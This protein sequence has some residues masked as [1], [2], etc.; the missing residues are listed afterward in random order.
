MSS[1]RGKLVSDEE[2]AHAV[3]RI[4]TLYEHQQQD[5]R[6]PNPM[7]REARVP[8]VLVA[9]AG[10]PGSG[11]STIAA[12]LADAVREALSD[13]PDPMAS[14]RKVDINDAEREGDVIDCYAGVSSDKGVEVCVMPMDG[15]HLYRKEL[16]AMPNAQEAVNRRGAEWTFN[17]SKL[18]D[19]LVAIRTPNE[20]GLYND[21]FVPSFDHGTGDPQER[22]IRIRSSAGVIIVEGNYVLYR[23]TPEWAAV[24]DMFDVK[25]FLACDRD[26]CTERLCQRHMK[27]WGINRREAMAHACGSDTVNGDLVDKTASNADIVMHSINVSESKL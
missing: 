14:F 22:D 7:V 21:V 19:D 17:P 3:Q 4:V 11:K 23:G 6:H 25:L 20:R 12:L 10:R 2:L 18:H 13:Q 24:N 1:L 9:L 15:Y 26:V 8:R 16:L 5:L 27:A